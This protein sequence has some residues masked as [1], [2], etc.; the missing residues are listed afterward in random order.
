MKRMVLLF[1]VCSF[2][3][4]IFSQGAV[5]LSSEPFIPNIQ[6]DSSI[7][8]PIINDSNSTWL[9]HTER[10]VIYWTNFVRLKP[11]LFNS[12]VLAPFLKQFP[13]IKS[14]YSHSLSQTLSR[15]LS[16]PPLKLSA[17]LL[18]L[19]RYHAKDLTQYHRQLSHASS[20]GLTFAQR[21]QQFGIQPCVAENL[22]QG[23]NNALVSLLLLLIDTG[24]PSLAHRKNILDPS[25]L[26]IGVSFL[27]NQYNTSYTLVQDFLCTE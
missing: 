13:V 16:L 6:I 22:Y 7:L 5:V 8:L 23:K 15:Q 25:N 20:D 17:L 3:I 19:S 2:K 10:E 4:S 11:S 1:I 18:K 24:V 14:S 27:P 12:Q 21:T 26:Y 9:S